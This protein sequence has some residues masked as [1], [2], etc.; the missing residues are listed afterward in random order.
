MKVGTDANILGVWS[1]IEN[2]KT[3]LDIGTGSGV[4]ALLL[5]SRS[6]DIVVDAIDIDTESVIES[7]ENFKLSP[8]SER[9]TSINDD[10]KAF[11]QKSNSKYDLII[12]NPPF[13]SNF[14]LSSVKNS[15]N[16]A[17]HTIDLNHEQLLHGVSVLL[18]EGGRFNVVVP[19]N[20]HKKL[21]AIA[22][23]SSLYVSR[24]LVIFPKPNREPNRINLEFR[25]H[26]QHKIISED[27]YVRNT[28]NELSV[29]YKTFFKDHL[30]DF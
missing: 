13:F 2:A 5:A 1:D 12:S 8:Y 18:N 15:R 6:E 22:G 29:Q 7:N 30:T 10:F 20:I 23:E 16:K 9:I 24:Q 25:R 14:P 21:V 28:D 3:A 19:Y 11:S 17:R 27:F 26:R 4:L